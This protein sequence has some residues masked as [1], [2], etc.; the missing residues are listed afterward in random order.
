MEKPRIYY[1]DLDRTLFDTVESG[2][3][4]RI[5]L[6]AIGVSTVEYDRIYN[7]YKSTLES[8][9][10]FDPEKVLDLLAENLNINREELAQNF[11]KED[12]FVLFP[13]VKTTLKELSRIH[14]LILFSEGNK[15][16]QLAKIEKTEIQEFFDLETSLIERRKMNPEVIEK[17]SQGATVVDDKKEVIE[18]LAAQRPDLSLVWISRNNEEELT[19][20]NIR[21]I[22]KLD[23]LLE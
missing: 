6:E 20:Q 3:N 8:S 15:N 18:Q 17:I 4:Y 23:E 21:T 5:A 11:W 9:T 10:D 16:W 7:E 13:E 22:R 19:G 12:N 1:L 2:Q 14:S